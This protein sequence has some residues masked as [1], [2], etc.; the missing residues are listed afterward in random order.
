MTLT[1]R[2][3]GSSRDGRGADD[4]ELIHLEFD[5]VLELHAAII[6]GTAVEAAD[7][8]RDPAGLRSALGRPA[9]HEHYEA[10]TGPSG[11]GS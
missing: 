7:H 6:G 10:W 9:M 2:R 4:P 8:L 1:P 5:D 3:P 11:F